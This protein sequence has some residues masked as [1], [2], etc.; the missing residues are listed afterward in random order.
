MDGMKEMGRGI[1]AKI[2]NTGSPFIYSLSQIRGGPRSFSLESLLMTPILTKK[3][4]EG[5]TVIKDS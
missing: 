4:V 5:T 2:A 3:A 1:S